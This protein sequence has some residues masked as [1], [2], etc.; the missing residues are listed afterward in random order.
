[1]K[2]RIVR[3][4]LYIIQYRTYINNMYYTWMQQIHKQVGAPF[5]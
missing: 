1:M 5:E 4:H 2:N 3:L